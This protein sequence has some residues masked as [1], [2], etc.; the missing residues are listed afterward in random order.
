VTLPRGFPRRTLR[1]DREIYRIHRA[2]RGPWWFSS[3]GS[4][5]FDPV[6]SG[7]GACYLAEQPMGAWVE[8]FRKTMLIAEPDIRGRT[9]LSVRP[10]RDLRLADLT[11][12]RALQFGVTASLGANEDYAASQA[13]AV[14]AAAAGFAGVRYLVRHDPAQRL[15]GIALF[16]AEG[17]A[18]DESLWPPGDAG[19]IHD[20]LIADA[21][22]VFGYRVLPV[23]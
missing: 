4:G 18:A 20:D 3:D 13:F 21:Q 22:R 11:S 17:A 10:G 8:V 5:R 15:E 14:E 6:G 12:R 2:D 1:G 7:L 23:P 16:F 19:E 9:R